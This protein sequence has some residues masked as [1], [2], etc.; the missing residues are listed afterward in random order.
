LAIIFGI[1][2]I[3]CPVSIGNAWIISTLRKKDDLNMR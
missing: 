2:E 1:E 3:S